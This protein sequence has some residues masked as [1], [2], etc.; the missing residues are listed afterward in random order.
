MRKTCN[1]PG[2]NMGSALYSFIWVR[3][4]NQEPV[5]ECPF[6]PTLCYFKKI[7][8]IL[9]QPPSSAYYPQVVNH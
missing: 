8:S 2:L 1:T 5:R 6:L 4:A 7:M 9:G 3:E